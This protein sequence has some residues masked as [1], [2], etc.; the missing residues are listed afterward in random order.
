MAYR[1]NKLGR[2]AVKA[3]AS[4]FGTPETSFA[5]ANYFEAEVGIP[6]MA[7]EALRI[8]PLR[9][10]FEESEV[11]AG[12]YGP[13]EL[14]FRFPLHGW[15]TATPSTDPTE[16]PDALLMRLALGLA[17][18]TGYVAAN[19]ASGGTTSSVKFT[20]GNPNWEGSGMLIPVSGTP[21][22]ELIAM[23]DIDT[24]PTPDAGAPLV[25]MQRTPLS[26]G[27]HF[28]SNTIYLST[29]TP[30]PVTLDWIGVDAG[31]H[32]RYSDGLVKSLRVV[33]ASRKNPMVECT[34]RFTGTPTFPGAGGSLSPYA[35]GF[36][37]IPAAVQGNGAAMYFNGAWTG[38][39]EATFGVECTLVDVE[40]WA[41]PE[42]I[43][44]QVV[45]DRKVSASVIVPSTATFTNELLAPGAAI[46]KLM[47][48][49]ACANPGR[50]SGFALPA[51]VLVD[52]AKFG[53]RGGLLAMQYDMAPQLFSSDGGVGAGAG[54][55]ST[56]FFFA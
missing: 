13:I 28:G 48:I 53:D 15:S 42:G 50:S 19:I 25:T 49:Y 17:V 8:D 55:K 39:A 11:L 38:I 52:T 4:G 2:I 29:N 12:G 44:Q 36:P 21:G 46:S 18:Q 26:S 56:R 33:G 1:P 7:R 43:A 22:Y 51:P 45:T 24:T 9:S 47:V 32:V 31:H 34:M 3:Q 5:A 35:Y 20:V 16:H 14:A 6:V 23:S 41:S 40:G 30:N 54:N 27:A 37:L 10:G